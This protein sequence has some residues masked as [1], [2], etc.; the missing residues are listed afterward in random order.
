MNKAMLMFTSIIVLASATVYAQEEQTSY[1]Q[2]SL[3]CSEQAS[4]QID[5][6]Y[7]E[8]YE[9]CMKGKGLDESSADSNEVEENNF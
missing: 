1:E 9:S 4:D 2:A 3:A 5:V 8:A 6:S 7:N